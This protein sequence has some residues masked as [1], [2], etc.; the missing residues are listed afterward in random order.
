MKTD[1]EIVV[2]GGGP[3]GT[4]AARFAS[5]GGAKVLLVERKREFGVPTRCAEGVGEKGLAEFL[6]PD[7]SF[8]S[9]RLKGARLISP[10]G[11]GVELTVEESG[12]IL[13]RKIFDRKL[14]ELA[15]EAGTEI[16]LNSQVTSIE[17]AGDH[18][19]RTKV[20]QN[21]TT[22]MVTSKIVIA[23]DGVE[24]RVGRWAGFRTALSLHNI[25]SGLQYQIYDE[26]VDQDFCELYFGAKVAPAGYLWCFPKGEGVGSVGV[27]L[28]ADHLKGKTAKSLLDD[29]LRKKFPN[30]RIISMVAGGIPVSA[31]L[32]EIVGDGIMLVGDAARQVNP[33]TGAGIL[34]GMIA[35]KL[36]GQVAASAI[37][38]GDTSKKRLKEYQKLWHQRVGRIHRAY[39]IIKEGVI[40]LS[41]DSLNRTAQVLLDLP[42]DKRTL[43]RVF[44]AALSRNPK[45]LLELRHIFG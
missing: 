14:A 34:N 31:T 8:I 33:M 40:R 36:A 42:L 11:T 6:E 44:I 5:I 35:G 27:G 17:R 30:A 25:E 37:K 9:R 1:F 16:W 22:R 45:L 41:D 2:I 4:T 28:A 7:P 23:A 29:F 24:S 13:E 18:G 43:R 32:K 3:A 39:Y 20:S 26:S 12:F 19:W 38:E 21:G 15:G 10:D